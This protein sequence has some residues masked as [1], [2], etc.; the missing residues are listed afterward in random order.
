MLLLSR[1]DVSVTSWLV[2]WISA[3]LY[4]AFSHAVKNS[5]HVR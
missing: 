5:M 1:M 3:I 4:G 2:D